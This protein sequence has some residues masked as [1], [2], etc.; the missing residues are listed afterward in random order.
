MLP[1]PAV[2]VDEG[3][4]IVGAHFTAVPNYLD[5]LRLRNLSTTWRRNVAKTLRAAELWHGQDLLDV[6]EQ[7]WADWYMEISRRVAP[8]TR[9][10]YLSTVRGFYTWAVREDRVLLDPTRRLPRP[11]LPRRLP[12]PISEAD[13]FMAL[14]TAPTRVRPMLV[15][16][17]FA[18][19][20]AKEIAAL[21]AADVLDDVVVV[22]SGK[23][24]KPRK[25]PMH[26]S[27]RAALLDLPRRGPL[28]PNVKYPA[29]PLEPWRVSQ[30]CNDHL[31]ALGLN[32]TLHK[33]RHRFAT[34]LYPA[35]GHD[36]R[37]VQEMLGHADPKT[38]AIYA[39]WQRA[40][41]ATVIAALPMPRAA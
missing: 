35:S 30:L 25:V 31:H 17:A 33:L 39:D 40:D 5:H 38:T 22:Q 6:G 3:K 19:L 4:V 1:F 15:L 10:V 36:L 8:G 20:R 32:T 27:V 9:A 12:R 28:F 24:G 14:G 34:T 11:R 2:L 13:L 23:G 16:A 29:I 41:A 7:A 26:P 21:D 18:G 37:F